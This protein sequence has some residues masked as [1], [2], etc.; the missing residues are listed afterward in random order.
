MPV[1]VL[2]LLD[3]SASMRPH[4]Q[5]VSS[6]AHQAMQALGKDDRVAIMVFDRETRLR[7]PFRS[8]LQDVERELESLLR[9]ETFNGGT[10]ITRGLLDAAEYIGRSGRRDARRA[11]VIL[12][13]DQTER[14]RDEEG[15]SRALTRADAVLSALIAP[16]AIRNGQ[17][18]R[19]GGRYPSGGG[20][21]PGGQQ[22]GGGW[23]GSSGG[24]LGGIILGPRG[25]SGR[26][27]GPVTMGSRTHSAGT[28]EIA[29]ASGGDSVPVDN[30]YALENTLARIRQRYALYFYLPQ[31]VKPGEERGVEVLLADAA[32]SRYSGADVR[33]RRVYLAPGASNDSGSAEPTVITRSTGSTSNTSSQ[34][35]DLRRRRAISD[36]SRDGPLQV[37][38][39]EDDGGWKRQ[40]APAQGSVKQPEPAKEDDSSQGGWRR[41][42]PGEKP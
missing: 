10:D 17:M 16:D 12:T 8:S 36:G 6:A 19:S 32:R 41:V 20:G 29:R 7:L 1:D 15:V 39:P 14:N 25:G 18:S 30:A 22:G 21:Y 35:P 27:N 4:V 2:L 23:P 11:I 5:R 34:S 9:Q 31:G 26:R 42:K 13:D 28:S 24:P 33:Y 38:A 37:G 3:V 40:D